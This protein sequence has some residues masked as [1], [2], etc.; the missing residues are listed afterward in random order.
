MDSRNTERSQQRRQGI[1]WMFTIPESGFDPDDIPDGVQYVKGQLEVGN[2][3]GYRHW[4]LLI[5]FK[6]KQ[7]IQSARRILGGDWH[8]E[9]TRSKAADEYV[10]KEDTR[11]D[12]TQF[13]Y[14]N[15]FL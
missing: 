10:W 4:Q 14:G 1:Y 6:K 3:T 11:V 9:L 8:G 13:E 5:V 7:S 12:G 15:K 2:E